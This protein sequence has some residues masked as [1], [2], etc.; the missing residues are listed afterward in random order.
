MAGVSSHEHST[1]APQTIR[2]LSY[3]Y[4]RTRNDP[5]YIKNAPLAIG[6]TL[7]HSSL[8]LRIVLLTKFSVSE[9]LL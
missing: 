6:Q 4:R 3:Q 9:V 5:M 7:G 1:A 8:V 2:N